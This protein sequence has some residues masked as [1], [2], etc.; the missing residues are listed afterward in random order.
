MSTRGNLPA[1]I[2]ERE[3]M[4]KHLRIEN[5]DTSNHKVNIEVW[6]KNPVLEDG[7]APADRLVQI[8]E[9]NSPTQLVDQTIWKE[10]Y[11]IIREAE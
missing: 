11:L 2:P 6:E 1:S 4:T 5:A 3:I 8:V 10:R 7:K 9:L